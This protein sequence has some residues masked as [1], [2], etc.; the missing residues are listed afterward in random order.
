ML[1]KRK[2]KHTA[3][4]AKLGSRTTYTKEKGDAICVRLA[5]GDSLA[6]I[7]ESSGM[8]SVHTVMRWTLGDAGFRADYAHARDQQA[9]YYFDAMLATAQSTA[10]DRDSIAKQRLVLDTLKWVL[11]R[12]KPGKY[13][14]RLDVTSAGEK[15]ESFQ[16][17][18]P[19]PTD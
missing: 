11:S 7:C 3:A 9:E 16:V 2:R 14:D 12:M 18:M 1:K 4:V 6:A 8:P 15:L 19:K 17:T 10:V 13:G 5:Q